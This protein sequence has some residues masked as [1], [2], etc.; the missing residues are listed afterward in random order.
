[1]KEPIEIACFEKSSLLEQNEVARI[2]G[3][4]FD[5][6]DFDDNQYRIWTERLRDQFPSQMLVIIAGGARTPREIFMEFARCNFA[7]LDDIPDID[8]NGI[9]HPELVNCGCRCSCPLNGLK[10]VLTC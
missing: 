1:M 7:I 10:C 9:F 6:A 5:L 3:H 4:Y 8:E 2:A